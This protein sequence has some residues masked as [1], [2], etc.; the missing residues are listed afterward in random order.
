MTMESLRVI[1][2]DLDVDGRQS[3]VVLLAEDGT[4][5]RLGTG[6]VSNTERTFFIGRTNEALFAQLREQ[7]EPEWIAHQGAYDVPDKKGS[8]CTLTIMFKHA[9]GQENSF[10]FRY[11]SKSQGPPSDICQFVA[12]AVRLTDPWYE[13][14]KVSAGGPART[15]PWWKV[16]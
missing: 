13:Q 14:Q 11:G 15:K 5:N 6:A 12:E 9:D 8:T 7:V 3:L 10:R 16:W 2:V 1:M 4:V